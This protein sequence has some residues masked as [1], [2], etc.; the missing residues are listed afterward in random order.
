MKLSYVL[1]TLTFFK[2]CC[3]SWV[4]WCRCLL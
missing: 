1:H 3:N 2:S 4:W